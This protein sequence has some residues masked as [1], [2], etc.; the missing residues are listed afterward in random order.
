MGI[1]LSSL[2][3]RIRELEVRTP[4]GPSGQL[5]HGT[6]YSFSYN[7]PAEQVALAMP[8]RN[9]PY[10]HGALHPIFEMNLPEGFVRRQLSERLQRYTRISDMLFLAIQGD[11]GI[12]RLQYGS[13]IVRT[14]SVRDNLSDILTW[15]SHHSV[16]ADLLDRHLFNTTLSGMQPKVIINSDKTS[17][18]CPDLIVKTGGEDYPQLALNEYVCMSIAAAVGLSTP[19]FWISDNQALFIVERF[20][21]QGDEVLGMEDFAVLMGRPGAAR[22]LGS[23]ENAAKVLNLYTGRHGETVRFYRYVILSCLLGN[24]DAHLKNFALLYPHPGQAA[25]LS[26][27]YDVV[28]TQVYELEAKT[29]ALKMNKSQD[30]PSR[31]GVLRFAQALGVKNAEQG[32]EKMAD[33]ALQQ[34]QTIEEL[35][36]FPALKRT[37]EKTISHTVALDRSQIGYTGQRKGQ[38]KRKVDALLAPKPK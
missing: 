37:L 38:K 4:E 3:S 31:E 2:P 12:G 21:I 32:L 20:D 16:F 11:E 25:T 34:L 24:G 30:F 35:A 5:I 9:A 1:D 18:L 10:N 28:C 27:I 19:K 36:D 7:T 14:P 15:D 13:S 8:V 26:P 23:Y 17:L 33:I 6:H 22:Y 29:L